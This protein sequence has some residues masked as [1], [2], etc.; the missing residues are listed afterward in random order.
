MTITDGSNVVALIVRF[1]VLSFRKFCTLSSLGELA[2]FF[3][4]DRDFSSSFEFEVEI[5][6]DVVIVFFRL[7]GRENG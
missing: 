4:L 6:L 3:R 2:S 5:K 7:K 1:S